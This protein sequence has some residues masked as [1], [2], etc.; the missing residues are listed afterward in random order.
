[1]CIGIVESLDV[2][3]N[4]FYLTLPHRPTRY[5]YLGGREARRGKTKKEGSTYVMMNGFFFFRDEMK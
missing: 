3:S 5:M 1:M 4:S 2:G